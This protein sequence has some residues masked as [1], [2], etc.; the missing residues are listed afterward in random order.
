MIDKQFLAHSKNDSGQ[1][2]LLFAVKIKDKIVRSY[3]VVE[4]IKSI[5]PLNCDIKYPDN[6]DPV[7]KLNSAFDLTHGEPVTV[8]IRFSKNKARY[9][10]EKTWAENQQIIDHPDGTI[11]L[12]MTTFGYRDVKRWIMSFGKEA[13]LLEPEGMRRDIEEELREVLGRM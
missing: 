6:F 1:E 3:A 13:Q 4:R 5:K 7:K 8:K 12:T 10:K 9:I 11:T 2:H